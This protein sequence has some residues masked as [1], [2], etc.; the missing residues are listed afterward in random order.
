M[1]SSAL[2]WAVPAPRG[3]VWLSTDQ[4]LT[5]FV[6]RHQ[7]LVGPVTTGRLAELLGA[8]SRGQVWNRMARLRQLGLIGFR[9]HP[10]ME[11]IGRDRRRL[12]GQRRPS[13]GR[14]G[15]LLVWIP[16]TARIAYRRALDDSL[17]WRAAVRNALTSTHYMGFT[18]PE[19][20]A[21]W[22]RGRL[23]RGGNPPDPRP[24]G[25]GPAGG[26]RR[27][28]PIAIRAHCPAGHL[29]AAGRTSWTEG[30]P[31]W[32]AEYRGRCRTCAADVLERITI[33]VPPAPARPDSPAELAD[34]GLRARRA[35]VARSV[36]TDPPGI[37]VLAQRIRLERDYLAPVP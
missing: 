35:I 37:R 16:K 29:T 14:D 21:D 22:W 12:G 15:R 11:R 31:T 9:A 28:P 10:V 24:P 33:K 20:A 19:R 4:R 17:T 7:A 30:P 3:I 5:L 26:R 32:S 8:P 13:P 36:L 6:T 23:A 1:S 34:P 25:G 2:R 27:R 18:G